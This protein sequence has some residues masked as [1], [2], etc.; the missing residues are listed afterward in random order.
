MCLNP[1]MVWYGMVWYGM[2]WYGMVWYGM[3]IVHLVG[4]ISLKS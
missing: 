2:V 3:G 1:P 4:K